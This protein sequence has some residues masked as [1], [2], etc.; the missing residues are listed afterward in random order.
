[1]ISP[2]ANPIYGTLFQSIVKGMD[3]LFLKCFYYC[4]ILF[5][6]IIWDSIMS[7]TNLDYVILEYS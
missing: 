7:C 2:H 6:Y 1:M 3:I 5:I 4:Y